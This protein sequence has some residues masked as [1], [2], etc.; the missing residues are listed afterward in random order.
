MLGNV[1]GAVLRGVGNTLTGT[2][3]EIGQLVGNAVGGIGTGRS[4]H[5]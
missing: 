1:I 2:T 5:C 3:G 4:R